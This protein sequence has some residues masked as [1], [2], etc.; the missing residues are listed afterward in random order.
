MASVIRPDLNR[1]GGGRWH[2]THTS[3]Q[4][5]LSWEIPAWAPWCFVGVLF[6][7][8]L[9]LTLS[10]TQR[11]TLYRTASSTGHIEVIDGD[12]VRQNGQVF[13]LVGFNAPET[14]L[15]AQCS[16]ERALAAK[17][18]NRLQ[19]LL[20]EGAPNLQRVA[21]ACA[22]GTEGTKRCNHGRLCGKLIV[23]GR[24]VGSILIAEGL[25]ERFECWAT[26]CPRRKDWCRS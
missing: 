10:T 15:N 19:Q 23:D 17:A 22:P 18:T 9:Y 3:K 13:R 26:S 11:N 8:A 16:S 20:A 5:Q 25:A 7:A 21:C 6:L 24:N 14:G 4:G 1:R 2:R 12:T